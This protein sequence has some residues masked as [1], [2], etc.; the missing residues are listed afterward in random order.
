M[1]NDIVIV[2]NGESNLDI[3]NGS[4]IDKFKTVVRLGSY[5]TEG[6]EEYVG[7]KTDIISTIYWKLDTD[8]LKK[9]K[10]ILNVPLNY[11]ADFLKSE[12][13]IDAELSEYTDNIIHLNTFDDI[14]G[15]KDMYLSVMPPFRGIGN[16]NFSLGFKTFYFITKLFPDQRIYATGFD[17]F[18]TGW[19]WDPNHNRND[20]NLHPYIWERLWYTKMVKDGKINEI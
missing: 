3:K 13:F 6:F 5:I 19:Y 20:S 18:K 12:E 10:V 17:F 2:G 8:R 14:A 7:S 16:I 1:C 4:A 11:Q 9:H 15:I